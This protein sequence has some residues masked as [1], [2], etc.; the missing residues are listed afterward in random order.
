LGRTRASFGNVEWTLDE[1]SGGLKLQRN[2]FGEG[3]LL[4]YI[5]RQSIPAKNESSADLHRLYFSVFDTTASKTVL[6]IFNIFRVLVPIADSRSRITAG[7]HESAIPQA[8][9]PVKYSHR[10]LS[11]S[12][13]SYKTPD[14]SSTNRLNQTISRKSRSANFKETNRSP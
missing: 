5:P 14:P 12:T 9:T 10:A 3:I 4:F 1:G 2:R 11:R 6:C 8:V 7:K 13:T